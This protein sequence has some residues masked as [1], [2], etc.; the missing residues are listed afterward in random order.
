MAILLLDDAVPLARAALG[1]GRG[2]AVR[3]AGGVVV[4]VVVSSR[5]GPAPLC[6]FGTPGAAGPSLSRLD[7]VDVGAAGSAVVR[8]ARV[9]VVVVHG[10]GS[11]GCAGLTFCNRRGVAGLAPECDASGDVELRPETSELLGGL[12]PQGVPTPADPASTGAVSGDSAVL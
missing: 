10:A 2:P 11:V 6:S 3:G 7:S 1:A 12:R 9:P 5:A 8:P 4:V